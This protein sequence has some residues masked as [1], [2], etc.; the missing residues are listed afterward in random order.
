MA[1]PI[2]WSSRSRRT[3]FADGSEP[4]SGCSVHRPSGNLQ[5]PNRELIAG[6]PGNVTTHAVVARD[7]RR[8]RSSHLSKRRVRIL[9]TLQFSLLARTPPRDEA[10]FPRESPTLCRLRCRSSQIRRGPW[11][12]RLPRGSIRGP[13]QQGR[14]SRAPR[15]RWLGRESWAKKRGQG[16][17]P[18]NPLRRTRSRSGQ[19]RPSRGR[20]SLRHC[21][22]AIQ[23]CRHLGSLDSPTSPGRR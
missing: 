14:S 15:T 18:R 6:T 21:V 20:S 12:V 19:L 3:S 17:R 7:H 13:E 23:D 5:A 8:D 16:Q 1:R 22:L 10:P 2:F 9:D 4:L 11:T